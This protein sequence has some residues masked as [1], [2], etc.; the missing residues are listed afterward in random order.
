V[1]AARTQLEVE[2]AEYNAALDA[3]EVTARVHAPGMDGPWWFSLEV[4]LGCRRPEH[5]CL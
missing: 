5:V 1:Q 4:A 3:L 2:D